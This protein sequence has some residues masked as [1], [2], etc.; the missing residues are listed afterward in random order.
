M[1]VPIGNPCCTGKPRN[2]L[3]QVSWDSEWNV[4]MSAGNVSMECQICCP[5]G[6]HWQTCS[7][8]V[9]NVS[10]NYRHFIVPGNTDHAVE[11]VPWILTDSIIPHSVM[12]G[13]VYSGSS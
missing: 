2:V 1:V 5:H 13:N 3:S 8:P 10:P 12:Q 11:H 7:Q 6:S 4:G 9:R